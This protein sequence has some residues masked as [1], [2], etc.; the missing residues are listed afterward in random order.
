MKT[1]RNEP[2]GCSLKP[3]LS[4]G[5]FDFPISVSREDGAC[6]LVALGLK[7]KGK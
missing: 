7:A 3:F 1:R 2:A 6:R 5:V 4:S